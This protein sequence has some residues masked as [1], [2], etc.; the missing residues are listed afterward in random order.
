M[1]IGTLVLAMVGIEE[2]VGEDKEK[3]GLKNRKRGGIR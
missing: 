1:G 2:E 3:K